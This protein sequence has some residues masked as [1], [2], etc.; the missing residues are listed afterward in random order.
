MRWEIGHESEKV[1]RDGGG[2]EVG[3]VV[4]VCVCILGRAGRKKD[5]GIK[6]DGEK[7]KERRRERVWQRDRGQT[8][9]ASKIKSGKKSV[10]YKLYIYIYMPYNS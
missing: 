10:T 7:K 9:K 4:C 6:R 8:E 2:V 1:R 3:L 5:R